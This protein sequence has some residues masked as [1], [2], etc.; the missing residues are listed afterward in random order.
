ME[1]GALCG[2][3]E[4]EFWE[5]TPRY[6]SAKIKALESSQRLSWEQ[7]RYIAF[8][9]IK[10][11]DSKNRLKRLTDLGKFPWE[12]T[13][14]KFEPITRDEHDKFSDEADE[15]L[16]LTNPAAYEAYIKGKIKGNG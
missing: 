14:K 12:M 16:R 8:H 9:A 15:V 6:L 4:R 2:M 13:V 5:S 7:S 3:T 11:G 10:V 1:L